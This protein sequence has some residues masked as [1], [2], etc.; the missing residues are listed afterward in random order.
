LRPDDR[1]RHPDP[2]EV[3]PHNVCD[4]IDGLI[5][6]GIENDVSPPPTGKSPRGANGRPADRVHMVRP[7]SGH[8][9]RDV[10]VDWRLAPNCCECMAIEREADCTPGSNVAK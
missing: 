8:G 9:G 3:G 4:P 6:A 5:P 7:V 1:D 2:S 10:E